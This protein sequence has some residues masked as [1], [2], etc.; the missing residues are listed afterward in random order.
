MKKPKTSKTT[1]KKT[2]TKEQE[3]LLNFSEREYDKLHQGRGFY[4]EIEYY[5][6]L[7]VLLKGKKAVDIACGEGYVE[8]FVPD[9]VAV[10][11]SEEALKRAKKNG[12]KKV[13][14]ARA[15]DLPFAD[16]EFDISLCAGS[17]EH[18]VDQQGA[19]NEM[20]RVSKV[21]II[22]VHAKHPWYLR[23]IKSI[24]D[25]V[26]GWKQDQPLENPLS[27]DETVSMLNRAGLKVIFQGVFNYVDLRWMHKSL[28]YGLVKIPS[29]YF[30]ISIQSSH[31][32]RRFLKQ[33]S[34]IDA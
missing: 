31:T 30:T 33:T 1:V 21:Q 32:D 15:E 13:V 25:M 34:G 12:A 10:D 22:T 14:K 24:I 4:E 27:L 17:L 23:M 20:G 16:G 7:A 19:I 3:R 8:K 6:T 18:F 9:V 2:F 11:F 5:E 29:H 28:P 26:F